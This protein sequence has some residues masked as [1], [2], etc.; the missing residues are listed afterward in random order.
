VTSGLVISSSVGSAGMY[1]YRARTFV[2]S[3]SLWALF[4][5]VGMFSILGDI[6]MSE[7]LVDSCLLMAIV[8]VYT[9][10]GGFQGRVIL[11][12]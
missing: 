10:F 6:A 2:S 3:P 5:I 1:G 4:V 12:F 8:R 11:I 7:P 9:I